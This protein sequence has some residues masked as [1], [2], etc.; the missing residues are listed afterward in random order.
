M[1]IYKK[2]DTQKNKPYN[3]LATKYIKKNNIKCK[4]YGFMGMSGDYDLVSIDGNIYKFNIENQEL[5]RRMA[6]IGYSITDY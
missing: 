1:K 6:L 4:Y 2:Y 5:K 3:E